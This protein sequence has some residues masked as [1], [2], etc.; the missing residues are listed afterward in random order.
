MD[1]NELLGIKSLATSN[2]QQLGEKLKEHIK[3]CWVFEK[4]LEKIL[5]LILMGMG[6]WKIWGLILG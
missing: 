2:K 3:L 4:P 6:V 1:H 5:L